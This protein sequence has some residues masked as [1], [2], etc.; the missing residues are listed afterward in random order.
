M[1]SLLVDIENNIPNEEQFFKRKR[2]LGD[3]GATEFEIQ[4][5]QK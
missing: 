3:R 5:A 1:Q 2:Q 4:K